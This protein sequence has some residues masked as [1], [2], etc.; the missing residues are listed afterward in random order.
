MLTQ[1][2]GVVVIFM[3]RDKKFAMILPTVERVA[4]DQNANMLMWKGSRCKVFNSV[5]QIY[6]SF[7][8]VIDA[9]LHMHLE[10]H[11]L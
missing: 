10:I 8:A 7:N 2:A 4:M 6:N 5:I 3:L 1:C 11:N 9:N